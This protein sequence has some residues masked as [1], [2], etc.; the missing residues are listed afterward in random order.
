MPQVPLAPFALTL[1]YRRGADGGARPYLILD[2]Q[3]PAGATRVDGVV[4]SGADISSLPY[5]YAAALGYQPADLEESTG[6]QAS[7]TITYHRA[8]APLVAWL[9]AAQMWA[10]ALHP[11]F[12]EGAEMALWGRAD[13]F[14]AWH[15]SI[16]EPSQQFRIVRQ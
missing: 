13:F 15:V 1:A 11:S 4:D 3:G 7:G 9:P 5:E 14:R 12:V 10:F 8:A 2:V 6:T 16:S